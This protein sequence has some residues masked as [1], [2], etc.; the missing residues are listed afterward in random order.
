VAVAT[1][2]R[3]RRWGDG[4][5]ALT[6]LLASALGL[7]SFALPMLQDDLV[8]G[9]RAVAHQQDA[10]WL[11]LALLGLC[12]LVI[13]A[14][15][16]TRR[17]DSRVV[18]VLGVLVAINGSLRLVSGPLGASAVFLLPI[19]CAYVFGADFGFLLATLSML[20]S[21]ILTGG[22]GPWLPF[23]MFA[24]GWCA[25]VPGWL[26]SMTP[27]RAVPLLAVWGGL[28]G[29]L[30]GAVSNLWFWPYLDAAAA[31]GQQWQPHLGFV[32]SLLR[33]AAFYLTTSSWWDAGRAVG[34]VVLV[35]SFGG[36]VI[37]LLQRFRQ[38]FDFQLEGTAREG[39]MSS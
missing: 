20:A 12:L 32:Q 16:E 21:A 34:N 29:I 25:M 23:Q 14:N 31:P 36:P 8:Q 9:G 19:C 33:Y 13:V 17:M 27:R 5:S 26:P 35:I 28:C 3:R 24:A 37:R 2:G 15:L 38:R 7:W 4:L 6:L 18:A 10:P 39:Q 22:L 30:F 1:G 11:L